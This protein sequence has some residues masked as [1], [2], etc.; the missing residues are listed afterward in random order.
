MRT[1]TKSLQIIDNPNLLA[2]RSVYSRSITESIQTNSL[3]TLQLIEQFHGTD[4]FAVHI[5]HMRQVLF[6]PFYT[7]STT[8]MVGYC[9]CYKC[10]GFA[11]MDP[12]LASVPTIFG[13]GEICP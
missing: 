5:C 12:C 4:A 11:G 10:V 6:S 7:Q 13:P 3:G 9:H 2:V 8:Q 1:Q